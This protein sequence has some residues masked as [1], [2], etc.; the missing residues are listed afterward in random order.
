ML[1]LVI[2]GVLKK[3]TCDLASLMEMPVTSI[4]SLRIH[5]KALAWLG[6]GLKGKCRQ[7]IAC[8]CALS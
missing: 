8:K 1:D 4:K 6:D 2:R 3:K 7:Q 5:L